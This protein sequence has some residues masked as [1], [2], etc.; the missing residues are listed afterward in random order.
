[1]TNSTGDH[2]LKK[3]NS[4]DVFEFQDEFAEAKAHEKFSSK[5]SKLNTREL[6]TSGRD[7]G[8]KVDGIMDIRVGVKEVGR[9]FLLT[10]KKVK[11]RRV[12]DRVNGANGLTTESSDTVE[13]SPSDCLTAGNTISLT[14]PPH[15]TLLVASAIPSSLTT[16]TFGTYTNCTGVNGVSSSA[17][18]S[19]YSSGSY[20]TASSTGGPSQ[21]SEI[22]NSDL[23]IESQ[24]VYSN[25]L[26]QCSPSQIEPVGSQ[27]QQV[28]TKQSWGNSF[29]SSL[30]LPG[31]RMTHS[32]PQ[33]VNTSIE[34]SRRMPSVNLSYNSNGCIQSNTPT[35][36]SQTSAIP[37]TINGFTQ[38]R[39]DSI[40][41]KSRQFHEST[42]QSG[43]VGRIKDCKQSNPSNTIV[44]TDEPNVQPRVRPAGIGDFEADIPVSI[45]MSTERL[46]SQN[47]RCSSVS[48]SAAA[49]R[50]PRPCDSAKLATQYGSRKFDPKDIEIGIKQEI[51]GPYLNGKT[52]GI[53]ETFQLPVPLS[54]YGN[55]SLSNFSRLIPDKFTDHLSRTYL[56]KSTPP[57][58]SSESNANRLNQ[59]TVSYYETE[60]TQGQAAYSSFSPRVTI[61]P[62]T[63]IVRQQR[64]SSSIQTPASEVVQANKQLSRQNT[65]P[66][67]R[68]FPVQSTNCSGLVTEDPNMSPGSN[69]GRESYPAIFESTRLEGFL[70]NNR[71][72]LS[73]TSTLSPHGS[74]SSVSEYVAGSGLGNNI[75]VNL[76]HASTLCIQ[77]GL[78]LTLCTARST[79]AHVKNGHID[80]TVQEKKI[81]DHF[82]ERVDPKIISAAPSL[83]NSNHLSIER[84]IVSSA[85]D[86]ASSLAVNQKL[87][88]PSNIEKQSVRRTCKTTNR[89]ESSESGYVSAGT[90]ESPKKSV[91]DDHETL[92][93]RIKMNLCEE[94]P[95]CNCMGDGEYFICFEPFF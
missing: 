3:S 14:A 30:G 50:F 67:V 12:K 28:V 18:S 45:W 88:K 51:V 48:I 64:P 10:L 42:D 85:F 24:S 8:T 94:I 56:C 53:T 55:S 46:H 13:G 76:P 36:I 22:S 95:D 68:M 93:E 87:E 62:S 19:S 9:N 17:N 60:L 39:P 81:E 83:A 61:V 37:A 38:Y 52:L 32:V 43:V 63:T 31:S 25:K 78:D 41:L 2:Q 57:L 47:S 34:Y 5:K 16:S 86:D 26:Y 77:N 1:M 23:P 90:D 71:P 29:N 82:K 73:S 54:C 74:Q 92:M 7:E 70:R 49:T 44:Q 72:L 84:T 21:M 15:N 66:D 6:S 79:D 59:S 35:H 40:S 75:A 4:F 11:K 89:V 91:I 80:K 20:T 65:F 69:A 33:V 58:M 27:Y